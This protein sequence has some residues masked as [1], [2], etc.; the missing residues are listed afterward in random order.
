MCFN[1]PQPRR[2]QRDVLSFVAG[3]GGYAVMRPAVDAEDGQRLLAL[4]WAQIV[5]VVTEG[6]GGG[7]TLSE[8]EPLLTW[9]CT[10]A[11]WLHDHAAIVTKPPS[12]T[13]MHPPSTFSLLRVS[14]A[15][16]AAPQPFTF[17]K[18]LDLSYVAASSGSLD[19][20]IALFDHCEYGA[21]LQQQ[22]DHLVHSQARSVSPTSQRCHCQCAVAFLQVL[23]VSGNGFGDRAAELVDRFLLHASAFA[24]ALVPPPRAAGV[25]YSTTTAPA[26]PCET[27]AR[28]VQ[29]R[30]AVAATTTQQQQHHQQVRLYDSD[31]M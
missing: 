31:P 17:L 4:A 14:I 3:D 7:G 11:E 6:G 1:T 26:A 9:S 25:V 18:H 24:F 28:G 15:L 5:S 22:Q 27:P 30:A 12:S 13:E 20:L 2:F 8:P 16:T 29:G 21:Q 23:N 19:A 10:Q